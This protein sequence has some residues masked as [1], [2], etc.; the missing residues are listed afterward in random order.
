VGPV[1]AVGPTVAVGWTG[2]AVGVAT[3]VTTV[4]GML[5]TAVG[6]AE[7]QPASTRKR[8]LITKQKLRRTIVHSPEN[9]KTKRCFA[10]QDSVLTYGVWKISSFLLYLS[11]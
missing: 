6:V 8:K 1:I 4:V 7:T 3:T 5:G 10:C 2:A 11:S 9:R